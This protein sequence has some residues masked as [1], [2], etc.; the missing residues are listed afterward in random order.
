HLTGMPLNSQLT[1]RSAKLVRV[2]ATAKSYRLY[3]LANTTPP[4]PGLVRVDRAGEAIALEIWEMSLAAFGSF[5]AEVP[6]P[7]AIGTL[8]LDDGTWCKGFVCEPGALADAE[9]ITAHRGWR[10]YLQHRNA[11]R[12]AQQ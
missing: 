2:A 9:D 10:A 5:V 8:E 6:A 1:H 3:A 11:Q 4:K 7:M 12:A